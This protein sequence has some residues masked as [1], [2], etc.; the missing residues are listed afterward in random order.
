MRILLVEDE[1]RLSRY[2]RQGLEEESFA[3][4]TVATGT[5]ALAAATATAY[6]AIVLD[7]MIP[8][9]DG[10]EVCSRLR[11]GKNRT[12][13]IMLTARDAVADRVKGLNA[14]ADD[15]L[16]KPF[17]FEELVARVRAVSRR[18]GESPRSPLVTI[19]NLTLDTTTRRVTRGDTQL[20][21]PAKE[22]AVLE[23]LMRQP[24]R[25]FTRDEIAAHV[26][27]FRSY[28]E[29]NVI[30]VYIRNLRRKIDDPFPRKLIR[31]I[32]GIGYRMSDGNG[33]ED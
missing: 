17:A 31:T 19:G 3:V 22:Y 26:W 14:G 5:D 12:P 28:T 16:V 13:I 29:S 20:E 23:C 4:D 6:D 27:D 21:L 9:V 25:V 1:A 10:F 33:D 32:R 18:T 2:V 30:N 7:V 24:E 8:G 11:A 15:Y